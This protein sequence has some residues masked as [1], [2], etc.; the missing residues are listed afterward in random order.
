MEEQDKGQVAKYKG[1][2][3]DQIAKTHLNIIGVLS[4][5]YDMEAAGEATN[6]ASCNPKPAPPL[7]YDFALRGNPDLFSVSDNFPVY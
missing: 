4:V 6:T 1:A 2:T 3:E 5:L 7:Q